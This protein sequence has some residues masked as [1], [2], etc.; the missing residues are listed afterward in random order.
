MEEAAGEGGGGGRRR[1]RRRQEKVEE[2][3][4]GGRRG[5]GGKGDGGYKEGVGSRK[6][7]EV[8]TRED[9]VVERT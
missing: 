9:S 8:A 3:A 4:G 5:V 7:Y 2:A 6:L 1:W